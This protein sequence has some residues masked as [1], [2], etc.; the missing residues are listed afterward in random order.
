MAVNSVLA[1]GTRRHVLPVFWRRNQK[2]P[3]R[4]KDSLEGVDLNYC[5]L[6][7]VTAHQELDVADGVVVHHLDWG[8]YPDSYLAV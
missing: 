1:L 7:Q 8:V 5:L 6:P 4:P 3:Q 2:D